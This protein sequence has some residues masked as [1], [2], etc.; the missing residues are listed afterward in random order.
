M[1]TLYE[2][3]LELDQDIEY[4]L[5]YV[6]NEE[7]SLLSIQEEDDYIL[8]FEDDADFKL[9]I[10]DADIF[11][12]IIES[13]SAFINYIDGDVYSGSYVFTPSEEQQVLNTTN[14]VLLDNIVINAIP[15]NYGLI[16]WNGNALTIS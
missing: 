14:C 8:D 15:S 2:V 7:Y 3:G 10:Q 1:Q 6:P 11:D 12:F 4:Q 5:T 13:S 16:T 9:E